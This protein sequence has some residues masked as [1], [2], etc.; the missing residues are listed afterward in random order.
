MN[1]ILSELEAWCASYVAA[2]ERSDS[3]LIAEHWIFPAV[4]TQAGQSFAFKSAEHFEKNTDRLLGFYQR[5]GVVSVH[6]RVLN[7]FDMSPTA[8]AMTV[9]D[10]MRNASG[11]ALASWGAAYVLQRN[12]GEWRAVAAIADGEVDAWAARGTPLGS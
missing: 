1:K 12:Q 9:A 8:V 6:R 11:A 5:Q 3:K 4:T 7:H 2:F 10:E